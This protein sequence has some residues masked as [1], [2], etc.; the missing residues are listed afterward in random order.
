MGKRAPTERGPG[1][2]DRAADSRVTRR[3]VV[4]VGFMASGKSTV[5]RILAGILSWQFV[6]TDSVIEATAGVAIPEIFRERG[7]TEFR[8]L[9]REAV[10][11][12]L[13]RTEVVIATG[14]G[15]AAQPGVFDTLA[16]G[17]FV[18]WL[19]IGAEEAVRRARAADT[20]RPLLAGDEPLDAARRLL[21]AREP[22]YGR[23]DWQIDVEGRSPREI[24]EAIARTFEDT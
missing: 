20:L 12:A 3:Q 6:D 21:Q 13:R 23:A 19:R 10:D 5:G 24:A 2:V 4:L 1:T 16:P 14:G 22:G 7:E 17:S 18:V 11:A 9:E 15:W 8:R